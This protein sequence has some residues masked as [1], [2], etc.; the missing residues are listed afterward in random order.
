M[1]RRKFLARTIL[2]SMS[3]TIF[4]A[5]GWLMGTRSLTMNQPGPTPPSDGGCI[6]QVAGPNWITCVQG[7]GCSSTM[8]AYVCFEGN[9]EIWWGCTNQSANPC[10]EGYCN[11]E[12]NGGGCIPC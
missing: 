10:S 4:T 7:S 1:N 5:T 11:F 6:H 2:T 9:A 3:A 12:P 8:C